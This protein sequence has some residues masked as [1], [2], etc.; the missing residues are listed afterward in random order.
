VAA[1]YSVKAGAYRGLL[2]A[3]GIIAVDVGRTGSFIGEILLDGSSETFAGDLGAQDSFSGAIGRARLPLS[4]D[5]GQDASGDYLLTGTA[6]GQAFTADHA[7]YER[8]QRAAETG[9]YTILF[10]STGASAAVP[11]GTG[12]GVL[13]VAETGGY[14]MAGKLADGE[15]FSTSGIVVRGTGG[16]EILI[17]KELTYRSVTARRMKGLLI[18]SLTF[19]RLTGSVLDGTL[20]WMKPGQSKGDYRAP[21]TTSLEVIASRYKAA[22]RGG[23][24]PGFSTGTLEFSDL[25]AL[26]VTGSSQIGAAVSLTADNALKVASPNGANVR[27][28]LRAGSGLFS[29]SFTY[30][31]QATPVD[32]GGTLFQDQTIGAGFF[33]GPDGSGMV[34]IS[35][36]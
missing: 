19:E 16:N 25:G 5:I 23:A 34:R 26:S 9:N 30:P 12:Y 11:Y 2:G 1:A 17:Y 7:A 3:A 21:F 18:G 31:G 24:L 6:G 14:I 28:R 22:G 33:L 4:M 32:F 29:G 8:G 36:P 13:S 15:G 27:I 35:S 20:E 10:S